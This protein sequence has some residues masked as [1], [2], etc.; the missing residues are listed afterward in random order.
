[1]VS[2]R[3]AHGAL[4]YLETITGLSY[5]IQSQSQ[6]PEIQNYASQIQEGSV[7]LALFLRSAA[8]ER[9]DALSAECSSSSGDSERIPAALWF[10]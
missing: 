2:T 6:D 3:V 9:S 5:L 7:A 4:N 1:M 10:G 8:P